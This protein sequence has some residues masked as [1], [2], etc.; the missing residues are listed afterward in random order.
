MAAVRSKVSLA[1]G[2]FFTVTGNVI[3]AVDDDDKEVSFRTVCTGDGVHE[4]EGKKAHAPAGVKQDLKCPFCENTDKT[5]F[6]KASESAGT[7]SIVNPEDIAAAEVD[8]SLKLKIDLRV[9]K[10]ADLLGTTMPGG[11]A[12]YFEPVKGQESVYSLFREM[13]EQSPDLAFC[14][15]WASRSKPALYRLSTFGKA[16][17]LQQI[18]WPSSLRAAPDV[19]TPFAETDLKM[20]LTIAN[21]AVSEYDP[22][23]YKDGRKESLLAAIAKAEGVEGAKV[24]EI[25]DGIQTA[26]TGSLTAMLQAQLAALAPVEEPK[27]KAPRKKA[28]SAA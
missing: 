18:A 2:A 6:K 24:D 21:A 10:A 4:D 17:A 14:A 3:S 5:T 16:L 26:P 25:V 8:E 7:F 15:V 22:A 1:L 27:K 19:D 9:H 12:Y 28:A 13:V 11:K 20:A 23:A